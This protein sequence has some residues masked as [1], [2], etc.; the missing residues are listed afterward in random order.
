M[1]SLFIYLFLLSY[2][3]SAYLNRID[4]LKAVLPDTKDVQ[5]T[6]ILTSIAENY[7]QINL[8]SSKVYSQAAYNIASRIGN[9]DL[10]ANALSNLG[11][12]FVLQGINDSAYFY[13]R[14][15]HDLFKET[16][17]KSGIAKTLDKMALVFRYWGN[18]RL[19]MEY[20]VEALKI[21]DDLQ[22]KRGAAS[23]HNNLGVI[24][25]NYNNPEQALW[26]FRKAL[27]LATETSFYE[28][29]ANSNTK[30]GNIYWYS[31]N[32][33]E[34][35]FYYER[36]LKIAVD[37]GI[38]SEESGAL[39]NI[40]NVFRQSGNFSKA[41][42]YY[43]KSL[44]I[45]KQIQD[46]NMLSVTEK[47]IGL[48]YKNSELFNKAIEHFEISLDYAQKANLKKLIFENY[49]YLSDVYSSL[50]NTAKA[51]ELY[52]S[53]VSFKDSLFNEETAQRINM[54]KMKYD[55]DS[56]IQQIELD[57]Q[58]Q[59]TQLYL[60]ILFLSLVSVAVSVIL[61]I[62]LK[63]RYSDLKERNEQLVSSNSF[64][65]SMMESIPNAVFYT[66]IN[67]NILG[68]NKDFE[69]LTLKQPT[70]I[71]GYNVREILSPFFDEVTFDKSFSIS[72]S[73]YSL[74]LSTKMAKGTT[75]ETDIILHK[76]PFTD[77]NG[78]L[79]GFIFVLVDITELIKSETALS[80]SQLRYQTLVEN[81]YDA[82]YLLNGQS[83]EYVNP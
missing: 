59:L 12:A 37:Y 9:K 58:K 30:I 70:E 23:A 14:Q 16:S 15:A 20:L 75:K 3:H 1:K 17:N 83:F 40:G 27:E 38:R 64:M 49:M 33:Q 57:S 39:N 29:I 18:Y 71:I 4:S 2:Q 69:M 80:E 81:A 51:F 44:A 8:D 61:G 34:A 46:Q 21:F 26:H 25:R 32:N 54:L 74:W 24:Y 66:D 79:N 13:Y 22:D 76:A 43:G 52:K 28:E 65:K 35:L 82:I 5:Y 41:L 68:C 45:S 48:V 10:Q 62:K 67:M 55:K 77:K 53:Y 56:E 7:L 78:V 31:G 50:G 73:S 11:E 36:A 72:D 63:R 47:N 19:S 60:V 6:K 42:E